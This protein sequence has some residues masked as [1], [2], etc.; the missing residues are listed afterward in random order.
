MIVSYISVSWRK[1]FSEL[2]FF[3]FNLKKKKGHKSSFWATAVKKQMN[4]NLMIF[5]KNKF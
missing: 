3:L 4:R 5:F 2:Y 1:I